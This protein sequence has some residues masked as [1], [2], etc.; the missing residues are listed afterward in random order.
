MEIQ[1]LA[2]DG[3]SER[4]EKYR[5]IAENLVK[6]MKREGFYAYE[7]SG[8]L[9]HR[10]DYVN[11]LLTNN[12]QIRLEDQ[13]FFA[14]ALKSLGRYKEA[15]KLVEGVLDSNL[16]GIEIT[17]FFEKTLID[18]KSFNSFGLLS[19]SLALK[20]LGRYK[21]ANDLVDKILNNGKVYDKNKGLLRDSHICMFK[22]D[23]ALRVL[24]LKSLRRD[25]E[26]NTLV[27]KVLSSDIYYINKGLFMDMSK[28]FA[29]HSKKRNEPDLVFNSSDQWLLSIV[30]KSLGRYQE[31]NEV[32]DNVLNNEQLYDK[33]KRILKG[34]EWDILGADKKWKLLSETQAFWILALKSLG[35]YKEAN[36]VID[37]VLNNE[38][39]YD[40]EKGLVK[41]DFNIDGSDKRLCRIRQ[42]MALDQALFINALTRKCL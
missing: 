13:A 28:I 34:E 31:A 18:C 38:E 39:L 9:R 2:K 19:F 12:N 1:S 14:L 35:R 37:N 40:K 26:A 15:H 23:Y 32:I 27:D 7:T 11:G 6:N 5:V 10:I 29:Y 22:K 30:L 33:S 36:E 4:S 25:K 3:E 42:Y 41:Q 17:N 20:S 16:Y 8:I 24:A 21:E